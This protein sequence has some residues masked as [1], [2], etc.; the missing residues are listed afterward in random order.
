M[1]TVFQCAPAA[2]PDRPTRALGADGATW[3]E[4]DT[5]LWVGTREGDFVGTIEHTSDRYLARNSR[6]E[7]IGSGATVAESQDILALVD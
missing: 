4:A 2:M 7:L 1:M 5:G 6:G 3:I